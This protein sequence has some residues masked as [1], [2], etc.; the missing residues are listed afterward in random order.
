M[1]AYNAEAYICEAIDS[2]LGQSFEDFE[3]IIVNDGST[4]KT[5]QLVCNYKDP[6]IIFLEKTHSGLTKSLN[7][8]LSYVSGTFVARMDADD[9]CH[10]DRLLHQFAEMERRPDLALLGSWAIQIDDAGK[11]MGE[12]RLPVGTAA[13]RS[14]IDVSNPFVH[15]TMMLRKSA[16]DAVAGY[17]EAFHYAQ[18][19]DLALRLSEHYAID[20]L[21]EFLYF[22]RHS[23]W[24][25]SVKHNSRQQSFAQL[26]RTLHGQRK[27]DG[28]DYLQRGMTIENLLPDTVLP[29]SVLDDTGEIKYYQH[30]ISVKCRQCEIHEARAAIGSLLKIRP[31][32]P[33]LWAIGLATFLGPAVLRRITGV[34]DRR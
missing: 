7:Y 15:G 28:I 5:R 29:D 32:S 1:C 17:R 3:F 21:A 20:N 6:R 27:G 13:I 18:D 2:V 12:N 33:K 23:I 24:M 26:A 30:L 22:S 14:Q 4:D 25:V 31:F 16:L 34:W 9:L 8:T 11:T 19:Y 10:P